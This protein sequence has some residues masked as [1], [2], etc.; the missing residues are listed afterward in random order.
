[1]DSPYPASRSSVPPEW[2]HSLHG[3]F[4]FSARPTQRLLMD[5]ARKRLG[6]ERVRLALVAF[7]DRR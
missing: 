3:R 7:G 2:M 4:I 5:V 1:M 6:A